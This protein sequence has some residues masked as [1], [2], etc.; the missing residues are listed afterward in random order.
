[1]IF[2]SDYVME[3]DKNVAA[4]TGHLVV[5]VDIFIDKEENAKGRRFES[6][7]RNRYFSRATVVCCQVEV[8]ASV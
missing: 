8:S 6:R 1:M 7:R 5:E 2:I 4:A 3:T